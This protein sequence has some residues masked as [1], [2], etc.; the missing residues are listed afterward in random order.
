MKRGSTSG[1]SRLIDQTHSETQQAAKPLL[2]NE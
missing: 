2:L 1:L